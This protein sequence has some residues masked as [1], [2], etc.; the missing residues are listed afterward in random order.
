[1]FAQEMCAL[2]YVGSLKYCKA[3]VCSGLRIDG[4]GGGW[5]GGGFT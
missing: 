4:G 3:T 2:P 5:G 1:M